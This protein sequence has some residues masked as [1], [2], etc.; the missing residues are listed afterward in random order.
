MQADRTQHWFTIVAVLLLISIC[1]IATPSINQ[2]SL[3]FELEDI[4]QIRKRIESS[5][6]LKGTYDYARTQA[7]LYL[8]T[9]TQPYSLITE[10]SGVG[11][12]GRPVQHR[13]A[14]LA[15]VGYISGEQKYLDKGK[16]ILLAIVRQTEPDSHKHW[17]KHLQSAD[18]SQGL[19]YGYDFFG[20]LLTSKEDAE[21]REYLEKIGQL[22]VDEDTTWGKP[23]P[24]VA[25]CNHNS[26]H[27]GAL[28]LVAL[29]LGDHPGWL[30]K[31][32]KHVRAYFDNFIDET[33]YATEGHN[34]YA[35]GL[36][37]ACPFSYALMRSTGEKLWDSQSGFEMVS[38][39]I[40]WKLLPFDGR[41]VALNDNSVE[42]CDAMG[43]FPAV[44][45]NK[46]VQLWAWLN[47]LE[48]YDKGIVKANGELNEA[49]GS[50]LFYLMGDKVV[51]PIHPAK[52]GTPLGHYFESGRVFLRSS[53]EGEDAAHVSFT[54]GYD[55]H[56]GHNHKDENSLTFAALGEA[57]IIDPGYGLNSPNLAQYHTVLTV[58]GVGQIQGG[59]GRVVEYREAEFG[60]MIRGQAEE[61]YDFE[62]ALVGFADRKVYFVRG[63]QPYLIWRDDMSLESDVD[64]EYVSHY[65]SDVKNKL[66][67]DGNN[68]I[69][70]GYR[71]KASC[72]LQVYAEGK[73]VK[74][75]VD[76][77]TKETF[78]IRSGKQPCDKYFRRCS[79][80]WTGNNP[81][82]L[83]IALPYYDKKNLP[84]VEVNY[85]KK[86][87]ELTCTLRFQEGY[88]DT[89][90]FGVEDAWF[91][92]K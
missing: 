23:A 25:S 73:Q 92:R 17:I 52:A 1:S 33:G 12:A 80:S 21:V 30:A 14:T 59:R 48:D 75:A 50:F 40:L 16:E 32:N 83:S 67:E 20:H 69:I 41:M 88:V 85:N 34:Y 18:A 43:I 58:N 35:Y 42:S 54:S 64:A 13:L 81:R 57:F 62:A 63:P 27:H 71:G 5:D 47:S 84:K 90:V 68:V 53:W 2:P 77:L 89:L 6:W 91:E 26:V 4:P 24:G 51:E 31:A 15:M 61:A 55:F 70:D 78:R 39:Q 60:A 19:A 87:D 45:F 72:M 28:G 37:G 76:D 29:V 65:I 56:R 36:A 7:D 10:V 82:F 9:D 8:K 74:V 11:S 49:H 38:E 44:M 46:G 86:N 66:S 3:F 22:L 79:V